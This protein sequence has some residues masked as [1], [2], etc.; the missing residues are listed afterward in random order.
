MFMR[1]IFLLALS[2]CIIG[3]DVHAEADTRSADKGHL[4]TQRIDPGSIGSC[5]LDMRV[6]KL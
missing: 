5:R 2:S 6:V 3:Q 1:K 4:L